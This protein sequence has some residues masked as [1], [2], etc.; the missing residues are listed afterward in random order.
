MDHPAAVIEKAQRLEQLLQRVAQGEPLAQVC[1][2]LGLAVDAERLAK[3]QAKY[4][5][6]SCTWEALIDGRYG[7]PK[8]AHSALQEW[9]HERKRQDEELTAPQ[10][11]D[12]VKT[13]FEV[14]L[15]AG[16]INYLLR[17][18]ELTRP[19]GRPR[20]R[21]AVEAEP[22]QPE[23]P[24]QSLDNAGIFFLEAAKQE[25]GI[26]EA[27]ESCLETTRQAY[28]DTHPGTPLRVVV[29]EPET[30]WHKLDH[31]LYLPILN[32]TRPRDLYYYQGD[33]LRVLYG[34][35]Y[36]YLTLEH[37]LG[38]MTR[39]TIGEPLAERLAQCYSQAWYP[40]DAPL[41]IFSDWHVKPHWTKHYA[42]SGH[43][44]MWARVMPGTKQLIINGPSGYLLGG[45]NYAIDTHLTH[46]L[47]ELEAELATLLG[48]PIAYNIFDSE[49]S[50]Q[51]IAR[52]YAEAQREYISVLPR[53]GDQSLAAF[54]VQGTWQPVEGDPDREAV[55]AQW[56]DARKAAQAPRRLVLMRPV[57][58]TDPTR[59]Y[60]GR[61]PAHISAAEVPPTHRQ[62]WQYQERRIREM[63]NGAN[64][65]ANFGYTYDLVP[66]RTRQRRWEEA[67]TKVEVTQRKLAEREEAIANL[68]AQLK[69][70]KQTY[71]Q[72]RAAQQAAIEAQR[73][74]LAERQ[75]AGKR[76]RRCEQRLARG[77]RQLAELTTRF[78]RRRRQLIERL[79]RHRTQRTQLRHQLAEREAARDAIDT[80]TLCRER[81]LEKDQ[82][83]LDLQVLLTSLHDWA[84]EHYFAP[85][86]QRLEL[87]T[88]TRLI[89]RKP[90]R[91]TWYEDHIEVVLDAYRYAAQQRAMEAICHRFNEANVRWRDGR[92]LRI[93]VTRGP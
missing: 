55:D 81:H 15:S 34:F 49:G 30:L 91:V 24:S 93:Q 3:L 57:E 50:G 71:T 26:T 75:Q 63:V 82:I 59:V 77:E 87:D 83:M 79:G 72:E 21:P 88:A 4:E 46:L 66:N 58:G 33:G 14:E 31:L 18:V 51:P 52:R 22:E 56:A 45:W 23:V 85:E 69:Q 80:E 90:G 41:F 11:V 73:E 32:L 89:Y 42:H 36:K 53:Q 60:A 1:A 13:Q 48:R 76:T 67:Q 38:Q 25:M 92:L 37:F 65:N 74:E 16:H 39:L 40:G 84:C 9:L 7:H 78:Q 27:V 2:E 44:T 28:R 64:L 8:K 47:V 20:S 19:P 5:A 43:V 10:L 54:Q 86:W 62:R 70:L 29:S 35:S 61:I 12:E 68:W 6:G 17:K